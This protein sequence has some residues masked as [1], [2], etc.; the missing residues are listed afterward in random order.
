MERGKKKIPEL[1]KV[2]RVVLAIPATSAP[3]ERNLE[4]FFV[5]GKEPT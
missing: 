3:T 1:A 5:L 4:E 2:A